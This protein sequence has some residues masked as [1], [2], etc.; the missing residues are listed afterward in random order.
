MFHDV[1]IRFR[2]KITLFYVP[3]TWCSNAYH[4]DDLAGE[5]WYT[6]FLGLNAIMPMTSVPK[7][8]IYYIC[9]LCVHRAMG[10]FAR[11]LEVR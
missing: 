6:R 5:S 8:S 10:M 1:V 11:G 4:E 9:V 2:H 3:I 7:T